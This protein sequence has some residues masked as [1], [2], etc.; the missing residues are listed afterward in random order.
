MV[1]HIYGRT[2]KLT[3][4]NRPNMFIKELHL[5]IDYLK[6]QL[7][8]NSSIEEFAKKKKYY[9]SF[10]QN[11]KNGI[12]YYHSLTG[13]HETVGRRFTEALFYAE[14]KLDTVNSQYRITEKPK[15]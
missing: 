11:L 2:K 4:N 5:Y 1:D 10:Y 14:L 7:E 15:A 12:M 6:E 3:R 13:L 8:E 9:V